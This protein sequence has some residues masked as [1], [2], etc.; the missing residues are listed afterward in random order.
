MSADWPSFWGFLKNS[1][2]QNKTSQTI[3]KYVKKS[4]ATQIKIAQSALIQ[5]RVFEQA[6]NVMGD[7]VEVMQIR[8]EIKYNK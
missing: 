8:K 2:I 1:K 6:T 4:Y 7:T 5:S 3:E